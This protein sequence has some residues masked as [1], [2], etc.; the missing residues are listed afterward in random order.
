MFAYDVALGLYNWAFNSHG[1]I[2]SSP[3]SLLTNLQANYTITIT[4][5]LHEAE[6]FLRS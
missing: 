5:L 4:Y 3:T 2:T 6:S 1:K